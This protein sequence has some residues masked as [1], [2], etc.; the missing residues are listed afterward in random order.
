MLNLATAEFNALWTQELDA[1][2]TQHD[3]EMIRVDFFGTI[4]AALDEPSAFGL[5]NVTDRY[6]GKPSPGSADQYLF[7]SNY[8]LTTVAHSLLAEQAVAELPPLGTELPLIAAGGT[9]NFQ[10]GTE[11]PSAFPGL[12]WA[13]PEFDDSAWNSGQEGFGFGA[14]VETDESVQTVLDTMKDNASTLY[15]RH[16]FELDDSESA[17]GLIVRMGYND[18]FV[19]YVN[20]VE[21]A[22]S[23]VGE[24]GVQAESCCEASRT[25]FETL[26]PYRFLDSGSVA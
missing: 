14:N 21:V 7:W 1:L 25:V 4:Q 17:S 15:V 16:Q 23:N 5:T 19:A 18:A 13:M 11:E 9:W 10:P 12:A 8:H 22:R 6:S 3:V 24:P 26:L 20:G 2:E